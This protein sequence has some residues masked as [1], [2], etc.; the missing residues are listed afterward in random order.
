MQQ[1]IWNF[2]NVIEMLKTFPQTQKSIMKNFYNQR[3]TYYN[4]LNKKMNQSL[5]CGE[6]CHSIINGSR[7]GE[8]IYFIL[9]K[10][11]HIIIVNDRLENKIYKFED[12]SEHKLFIK[13]NNCFIYNTTH[14]KPIGEKSIV[15]QEILKWL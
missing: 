9:P 7:R 6:I 15:K 4:I 8:K 3:N 10:N 1:I 11:Y 14:W 13:M 12:Y 5:E 2:D